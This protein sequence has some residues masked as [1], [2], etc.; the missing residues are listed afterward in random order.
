MTI[1]VN[2]PFTVGEGLQTLIDE[3]VGKLTTYFDKIESVTIFFRDHDNRSQSTPTGNSAEIRLNVP[4]QILYAEETSES[5]EKSLIA[6]AEKMRK[7]LIRYKDQLSTH[8]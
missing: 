3:K 7:Q 6:A 5:F 8:N 4:G 1:Q 2:A